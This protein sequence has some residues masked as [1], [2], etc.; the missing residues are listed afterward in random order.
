MGQP[1]FFILSMSLVI[2]TVAR[3]LMIS[4]AYSDNPTLI[5]LWASTTP[6]RAWVPSSIHYLIH[7]TPRVQ[8]SQITQHPQESGANYILNHTPGEY[9]EE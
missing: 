7:L 1:T 8:W 3:S 9:A 5:L 4:S 2:S 6:D